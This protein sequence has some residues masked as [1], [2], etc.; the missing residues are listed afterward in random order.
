MKYLT[1][2][3]KT[4]SP[5]WDSV[6]GKMKLNV[7]QPDMDIEYVR[8]GA[9]YRNVDPIVREIFST[10]SLRGIILAGGA[11]RKCV[12]WAQDYSLPN[13]YDFFFTNKES[14]LLLEEFLIGSGFEV[15]FRC[16]EGKLVSLKK[17]EVKIQLIKDVVYDSAIELIETFDFTVTMF[18]IESS[19][20]LV[21]YTTDVALYDELNTILRL[22]IVQFPLATLKRV[23]KYTRYGYKAVTNL[24]S[25]LAEFI[26]EYI[27]NFRNVQKLNHRNFYG[28]REDN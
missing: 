6:R 15:V 5:L 19:R 26:D 28:K 17:D 11:A 2:E 27:Q 23:D 3:S 22:N 14:P 24:H 20:P 10:D 9:D 4:L 12:A 1:L 8:V 16:P 18:A 13:D 21:V 7:L 25:E